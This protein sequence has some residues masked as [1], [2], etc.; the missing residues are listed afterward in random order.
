MKRELNNT[1]TT[2]VNDFSSKSKVG[3]VFGL[4][5]TPAYCYVLP[6][7]IALANNPLSSDY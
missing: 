4:A 3:F 1:N 6:L 5:T 7:A 2:S